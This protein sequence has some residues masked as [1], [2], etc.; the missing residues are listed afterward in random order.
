[1]TMTLPIV[2]MDTY[3]ELLGQAMRA[4]TAFRRAHQNGSSDQFLR[5]QERIAACKALT[6]FK[7]LLE[8]QGV[9][10]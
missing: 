4:N 6:D 7:A 9:Q 10:A 5:N 2:D 8:Q 1:M 3:L